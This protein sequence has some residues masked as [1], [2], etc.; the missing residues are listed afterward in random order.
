M[1]RERLLSENE[2]AAVQPAFRPRGIRSS[3]LNDRPPNVRRPV[4]K[5]SIS[6]MPT[7]RRPLFTR[8]R[9]RLQCASFA[10]RYSACPRKRRRQKARAS[11]SIAVRVACALIE[12]RSCQN[13]PRPS[14]TGN[15]V[16]VSRFEGR[17]GAEA[18][19]QGCR[20]KDGTEAGASTRQKLLVEGTA[21]EAIHVLPPR[22]YSR[23]KVDDTTTPGGGEAPGARLATL[24]RCRV[25]PDGSRL[26][27]VQAA[28]LERLCSEA[29]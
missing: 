9:I 1:F 6:G 14:R 15:A 13:R 4:P 12:G 20:R 24:I 17:K 22:I 29:P 8:A 26:E 18:E 10:S 21:C 11:C 19:P 2:R 23:R 5:D 25:L 7:C 28:L 27:A 16:A 3:T